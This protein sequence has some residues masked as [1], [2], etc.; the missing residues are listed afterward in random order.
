MTS[1]PDN[2]LPLPAKMRRAAKSLTPWFIASLLAVLAWRAEGFS[3]ATRADR[4][5]APSDAA[6]SGRQSILTAYV[7]VGLAGFRGIVAEA[8]W[9][10]VAW[11]QDHSRYLELVQLSEW[12]SALDPHSSDAWA[13][14]SWNMAYNVSSV[15]PRDEDRWRWVEHGVSLLRDRA[16]PMN[17]Q[18][19]RLY[20]EL[21]WLFQ[22][23]IGSDLDR[24]H[25]AYKLSLLAEIAPFLASDGSAP[26]P[27]SHA[28]AR[29]RETLRMDAATMRELESRFGPIDWRVPASHAVY[30]ASKALA[31]AKPGSFD[32]IA[33]RRMVHQ[34]LTILVASGRFTG[35]PASKRWSAA[36]NPA[37]VPGACAAFE[38]EMRAT[39]SHGTVTAYAALLL[40][41]IRTAKTG[42][43]ADPQIYYSR[44]KDLPLEAAGIEIPPYEQITPWQVEK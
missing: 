15:L 7:T 10:R 20:R 13:Y 22:H 9:L 16:I 42:G 40:T 6:M 25:I 36:P 2:I 41:A 1:S 43:N 29:L 30:W 39:P 37:L 3:R 28:A 23:K 35:D 17:P 4:D 38:E 21:G 5:A 11:L 14:Q 34:S 33:A 26:D 19:S 18:D 24:A 8:L 27:G 31:L 44:L 12:I 32:E